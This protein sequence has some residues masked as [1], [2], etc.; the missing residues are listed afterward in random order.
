M[1]VAFVHLPTMKYISGIND[2]IVV[3]QNKTVNLQ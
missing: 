1:T 2:F 3:K